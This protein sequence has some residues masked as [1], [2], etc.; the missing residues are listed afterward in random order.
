MATPQIP[1]DILEKFRAVNEKPYADQAIFY[2]NAFWAEGAEA[3]AETVWGLAELFAKEDHVKGKNGN[4]LNPIQA[5]NLLQKHNKTMTALELKALLRKVD[6][7]ANGEMSLAEYL[8]GFNNRDPIKFITNPQGEIDPVKLKELEDRFAALDTQLQ[9]LTVAQKDAEDKAA[10]AA[11]A[12]KAAEEQEAAAKVAEQVAFDEEAKAKA[13]EQVALDQEAAAKAAAEDAKQ[14]AE[15]ALAAQKVAEQEEANAKAAEQVA[16]DQEAAAKA[17]A[18]DAAAKAAAAL[19]AQQKAEAE[20]AAAVAAE[21]EA[22]A[23][24]AKAA[25]AKADADVA[26][27]ASAKAAAELKAIEDEARAIEAEIKREEQAKADEIAR[28]EALSQDQTVGIVKRNMAVQQLAAAKGE[29]SL[30]LRKAKITQEA[31]VRRLAKATAAAQEE[32]DKA[33]ASAAVAK[34]A[35]DVAKAAADK[36]AAAKAAAVCSY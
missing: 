33:A 19:A 30:P 34:E 12:Q 11:V 24:A 28:L 14:K 2:L 10:A 22:S 1:A 25:A 31:V 5:F 36:A 18:E 26:A 27:E 4:E 17:S 23:E 13:A 6:Y 15:A 9:N 32:A 21:A 3:E 20:E 29:D 35:A 16:L 7:D 8:V